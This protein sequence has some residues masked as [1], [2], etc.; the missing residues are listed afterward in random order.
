MALPNL[1]DEERAAALE[2]AA[3]ARHERALLREQIRT[4][5]ISIETL[6]GTEGVSAVDRLRVS[7]MIESLPGYGKAKSAKIMEELGISET[8]RIKGLGARQRA[9]L[10]ERL[11]K[12]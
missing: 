6:L 1:T 11:K 3:Q 7:A 9:D 10:I 12:N 2:K 5:E 4:G 8:R